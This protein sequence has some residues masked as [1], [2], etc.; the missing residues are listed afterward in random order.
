MSHL[1][2]SRAASRNVSSIYGG[3][4]RGLRGFHLK[5]LHRYPNFEHDLSQRESPIFDNLEIC[6]FYL[7]QSK[8]LS[9]LVEAHN[10]LAQ[11]RGDFL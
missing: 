6:T 10:S 9:A 3:D 8:N 2:S 1:K 7:V 4:G 11:S 5:L